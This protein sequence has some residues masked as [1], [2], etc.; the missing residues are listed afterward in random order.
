M[1]SQFRNRHFVS[2]IGYC[3]KNSENTIIYEYME[4]ETLKSHPYASGYPCISWKQRFDICIG[5]AIGINFLHTASPTLAIHCDVKSS[6]I[7]LDETSRPKLLISGC[8]SLELMIK[9]M[10]PPI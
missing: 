1:L 6:N 8:Q 7:L 9:I 10:S 2:L 3:D 4:N 5:A